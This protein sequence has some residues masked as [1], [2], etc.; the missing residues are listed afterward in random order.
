MREGLWRHALLTEF[1]F[2]LPAGTPAPSGWLPKTANVEAA[3]QC[4]ALL[5]RLRDSLPD[6]YCLAAAEIEAKLKR[7]QAFAPTADLGSTDTFQ[8]EDRHAL[9]AVSLL[10]GAGQLR[11]ARERLKAREKGFWLKRN[12][13]VSREWATANLA[14][15]LLEQAE[16][17]T[18]ELEDARRAGPV[19]PDLLAGLYVGASAGAVGGWFNLEGA[20]RDL[21]S[22]PERED[23]RLVEMARK[24]YAEA[25]YRM[26]E[27]TTRAYREF[28][29]S[30]S[31]TPTLSSTF[32]DLIEPLLKEGSVVFVLADALRFEMGARLVDLILSGEQLPASNVSLSARV[33]PLPS[34]TP[35]GMAA[36]MPHA[37]EGLSLDL[38]EGL[39]VSV[40]GEPLASA[41]ERRAY[42]E[43]TL[44]AARVT[45]MTLKTLLK[46][47][48][49]DL[50][51]LAEPGVNRLVVVRSQEADK[52]GEAGDS[53]NAAGGMTPLL[54]DLMSAFTRLAAAGFTRFVVAADHGFLLVPT[55]E[56]D[57]VDKPRSAPNEKPK[58]GRRYWIGVPVDPNP[59]DQRYLSLD[60]SS[61]GLSLSQATPGLR[62]AFP[63][64]RGVFDVGGNTTYYHG[65][66]SLPEI[67]T[68][69]IT[70]NADKPGAGQQAHVAA[71][72][73]TLT[74]MAVTPQGLAVSLAYHPDGGLNLGAGDP[75]PLEF[76]LD[77]RLG[78]EVL[79]TTSSANPGWVPDMGLLRLPPGGESLVMLTPVA[80]KGARLQEGQLVL[81]DPASDD[82]LAQ[83]PLTASA[84]T[85]VKL[86]DRTIPAR[87]PVPAFECGDGRSRRPPRDWPLPTDGALDVL[88]RVLKSGV[89]DQKTVKDDYGGPV[90]R[91]FTKFVG[92]MKG[93]R[94]ITQKH[95]GGLAA[96][97][98]DLDLIRQAWEEAE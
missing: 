37:E 39:A 84:A 53:L 36:L 96:Y 46:T 90:M 72:S 13:N 67:I 85:G 63:R 88:K 35:V 75:T 97:Q 50:Q 25:A 93:P 6:A 17:V 55:S 40:R 60:A 87:A 59:A 74:V 29:F 98:V 47:R 62:L 66:P 54:R 42:L 71:Q 7:Q 48:L 15:R 30:F 8:F 26:A 64:N 91:D 81:R 5:K 86:P 58:A 19:T 65:G 92:T 16:R 18:R 61:V 45:D 57:K 51:P 76:K 34:I 10:A 44:G 43:R 78:R 4:S 94:F 33:T 38:A 68:P 32:H 11:E 12:P 83:F 41:S 20:Q 27:E 95:V 77:V 3:A 21:E 82:I 23:T 73:L 52:V 80:G 70:F 9:N 1:V 14:L 49:E 89:L 79:A 24:A 69:S 2:D 22:Q 31:G 28:G 56:P